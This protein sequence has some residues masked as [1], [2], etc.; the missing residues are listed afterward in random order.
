MVIT[1]ELGEVDYSR[2][3]NQRGKGLGHYKEGKGG[4]RRKK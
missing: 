1:G 2:K 3:L 4:E